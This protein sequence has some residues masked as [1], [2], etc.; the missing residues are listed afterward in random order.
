[1]N[2]QLKMDICGLG[3]YTLLNSEVAD[4]QDR[5]TTCIPESLRYACRFFAQHIGDSLE[6]DKMITEE[7]GTFLTHHLLHWIEVMSLLGEIWRAEDS[8]AKLTEYE[9]VCIAFGVLNELIYSI[10]SI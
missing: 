7:L 1:M 9:I 3:D 5:I 8:V 2:E 10:A 6:L 4:L